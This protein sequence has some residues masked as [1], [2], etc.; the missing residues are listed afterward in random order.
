MRSIDYK[1]DGAYIRCIL[2]ELEG[3]GRPDYTEIERRHWSAIPSLI[4]ELNEKYLKA[5]AFDEQQMAKKA[6]E[7]K[8]EV[9]QLKDQIANLEALLIEAHAA[10][11]RIKGKATPKPEELLMDSLGN[12]RISAG[13]AREAYPAGGGDPRRP[14]PCPT[15]QNKT[16]LTPCLECYRGPGEVTI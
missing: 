2:R 7:R 9:G 1:Q 15:C 14:V 5:K 6:A 8:D 10:L 11:D 16:R 13:G 4:E 3:V 12:L